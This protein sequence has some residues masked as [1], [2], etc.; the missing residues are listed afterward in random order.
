MVPVGE[1]VKVTETVATY[2]AQSFDLATLV[3]VKGTQVVSVIIAAKDEAAT[4]AD[5]VGCV[6]DA[7]VKSASGSGLVDEIVVVDDG[8]SDDTASIAQGAGA[9][10][11][12]NE[13]NLGKGGAMR[14][15]L[16]ESK[17][18][19]I[20]FLD[21]DVSNTSPLFVSGLI[22]PLLRDE[23][24]AL[25]KGVYQRPLNGTPSGG[26]RVN[27][28][29]ARPILE[30][31]FPALAGVRQPL[32][33][34]TASRRNILE[35]VGLAEGYGVEIALLI[36]IATRY[37]IDAVVQVDLG[38]RIHRNRDL[39]QLRAQAGEILRTALERRPG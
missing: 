5:V 1:N 38:V 24:V 32:A 2:D 31:L 6:R 35:T 7:H 12:R 13:T 30:V 22:A 20:C 21:A 27:E 11:V 4:I 39:Q 17:G 34:E 3:K 37:G 14:R 26:G 16:A 8:S 15:G 36:D 29:M 33:G 23:K 18:S 25:V 10:V 28:L 19:L 9:I